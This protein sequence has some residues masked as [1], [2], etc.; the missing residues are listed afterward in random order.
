M[1]MFSEE[2]KPEETEEAPKEELVEDL[3]KYAN[4]GQEIF[5]NNLSDSFTD[6]EVK[7]KFS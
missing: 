5:L 3:H 1:R 6:D 2:T 4:L 7:A